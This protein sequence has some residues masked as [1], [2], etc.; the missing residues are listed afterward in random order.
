MRPPQNAGGITIQWAT[1]RLMR[2]FN[3]APAKRGGDSAL[4]EQATNLLPG[5][6]EAPAKRGGDFRKL[7]VRECFMHLASMRPPQ[8]AG[9]ICGVGGGSMSIWSALQ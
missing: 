5:F 1:S 2:C 6:N 3:E 4:G 8:N 9:G 7:T